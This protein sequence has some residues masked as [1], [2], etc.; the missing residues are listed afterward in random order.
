MAALRAEENG[1]TPAL[2]RPVM[3]II[4]IK[5]N[6]TMPGKCPT[7]WIAFAL[8]TAFE[9][10]AF[11]RPVSDLEY[12]SNRAGSEDTNEECLLHGAR[13]LHI[14]FF[15]AAASIRRHQ[16]RLDTVGCRA[17]ASPWRIAARSLQVAS[18]R[19]SRNPV[20]A[21]LLTTNDGGVYASPPA[22]SQP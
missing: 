8:R 7:T 4:G 11:D 12:G 14:T 6:N 9:K 10:V 15:I 20:P 2:L 17:S 22:V 16:C 18:I 13:S 1:R 19:P 21:R 5:K 3:G